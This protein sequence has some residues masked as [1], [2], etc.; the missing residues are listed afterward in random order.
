MEYDS[1]AYKKYQENEL[2]DVETL[3][4]M[5]EKVYN[6][7]QT[8][9][10]PPSMTIG[11]Y[12]TDNM[13]YI[14]HSVKSG[15]TLLGRVK[16][17]NT[18]DDPCIIDARKVHDGIKDNDDYAVVDLSEET[19][20][21]S[22]IYGMNIPSQAEIKLFNISL[23]PA[24][25]E[26]NSDVLREAVSN[27]ETTHLSKNISVSKITVKNGNLEIKT[28]KG[29]DT[30]KKTNI[31]IDKLNLSKG[32]KFETYV[33]S[34]LLESIIGE[35]QTIVRLH[36]GVIAIENKFGGELLNFDFIIYKNQIQEI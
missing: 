34:G 32:G 5:K 28:C 13:G 35:G 7:I 14:K 1:E 10:L 31:E 4:M 3:R 27:E 2:K 12:F 19:E 33:S 36:Q 8:L 18:L 16:F 9:N 29:R 26:V 25:F 15:Y 17:L 30:L 20:E 6:I 23:F 22:V 24:T 21:V 11:L